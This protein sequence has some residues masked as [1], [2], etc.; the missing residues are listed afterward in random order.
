LG[1]YLYIGKGRGFKVFAGSALIPKKSRAVDIKEFW[2]ISLVGGVYKIVP[3][4]LAN[5][6]E[7]VVENIISKP[8]NAFIKGRQILDSVLIAT[9]CIDSRLGYEVPSLLCKLDI[10]KAFDHVNWDFFLYSLKMCSF[11]EKWCKWVAYCISSVRF[12]ILVNGTLLSLFSGSRGLRQG[13][14]LSPI[15]IIVREV[16]SRMISALVIELQGGV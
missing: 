4:V 12:S 10:E 7:L 8:Q 16:L 6:L 11:G 13:D 1:F 14:P 9:E 5:R 3:R 2:P 15:F